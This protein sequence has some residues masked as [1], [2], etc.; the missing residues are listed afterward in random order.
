MC[1]PLQLKVSAW[2]K[3]SLS[4]LTC[5]ALVLSW[6]LQADNAKASPDSTT[7]SPANTTLF[8][9]NHLQLVKP[10]QTLVYDLQQTGSMVEAI[11]DSITLKLTAKDVHTEANVEFM[12]GERNRWTPPFTDPQGNPVL[13][14]FLQNDIHDMEQVNGGQWRHFQKYIKLA[15][16]KADVSE[17]TFSYAGNNLPGKKISIQPYVDDPDNT[18]FINQAF[19]KKQYEFIVSNEVPGG[20]YKIT[21]DVPGTDANQPIAHKELLLRA[22]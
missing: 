5:A 22:P 17:T 18:K 12:T 3:F 9:T 13:M 1:L 10:E 6:P 19:V 2:S 8:A 21:T 4:L 16:E 20:I 15:L 14:L 7:F 11:K